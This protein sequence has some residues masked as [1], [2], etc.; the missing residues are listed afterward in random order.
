MFLFR[1]FQFVIPKMSGQKIR[2][3]LPV[4]EELGEQNKHTDSRALEAVPGNRYFFNHL[5]QMTLQV[6]KPLLR[7]TF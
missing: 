6:W 2:A 5:S 7:N 3:R 1:W 4:P